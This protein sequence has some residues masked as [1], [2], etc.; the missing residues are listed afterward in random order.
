LKLC[1]E[2]NARQCSSF[3]AEVA[4]KVFEPRWL[5]FLVAGAVNSVVTY[6]VYLG[7]LQ[8][9]DYRVAYTLS[10]VLGILFSYWMN[11][12]FVFRKAVSLRTFL[13]FP[14]VYLAQYVLGVLLLSVAVE[15]L[16]IAPWLAPLLVLA[17]TVPL[18]FFLSLTV[19]GER[20]A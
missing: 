14:L 3:A 18:T 5:R 10:F 17:I 7:L 19:F 4:L 1:I 2:S 12:A 20:K 6:V 9:V 11:A 13:S 8:F 16:G 15:W